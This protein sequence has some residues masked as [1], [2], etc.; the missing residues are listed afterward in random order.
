[1]I[2]QLQINVNTIKLFQFI[3]RSNLLYKAMMIIL[4]ENIITNIYVRPKLIGDKMQ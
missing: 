2:H 4:S 3:F 1:M